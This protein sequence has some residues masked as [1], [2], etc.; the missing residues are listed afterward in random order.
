MVREIYD[1]LLAEVR[2]F[3]PVQE[4][5]KLTSIHWNRRSA[6]AGVATRKEGLILTVKSATDLASPR[7][8]KHEQASARRWHLEVPLS[9]V[10]EVDAEI[11]GW[12]RASYA[13]SE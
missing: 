12:L 3:G 1:R 2:A 9:S 7:I 8:R 4:D 6:F 11:L 13:L 5:P 10:A